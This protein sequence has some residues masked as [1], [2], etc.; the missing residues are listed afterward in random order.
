MRGRHRVS[1]ALL[2]AGLACGTAGVAMWQA[3][4]AGAVE[5]FSFELNAG[6]RGV[7]VFS[8]ALKDA[9]LDDPGAAIGETEASL[10][11]GPVGHGMA[12]VAWPGP[13]AANGGTLLLVLQ[14]GCGVTGPANIPNGATPLCPVPDEAAQQANVPLRAEAQSGSEVPTSTNDQVPG[15]HLTA[16]ALKDKVSGDATVNKI[17]GALGSLGKIVTHSDSSTSDAGGAAIGTSTVQDVSLGQGAVKIQSIIST[18]KATT[19]G[20]TAGGNG[21]T[22]ISGLTIGGQPATIDQHG[23]HFG[24]S[25]QP[26]NAVANQLAQQALGS[27]G[28]GMTL[29]APTKEVKGSAAVVGAPS[30]VI[31]IKMGD[32]TW[33]L[34]FGGAKASVT[35]APGDSSVVDDLLGGSFD[36]SSSFDSGGAA[37]TDVGSAPVVD[38]PSSSGTGAGNGEVALGPTENAVSKGRPIRP[39]AVL[40]GVLAAGLLA[41]GMKRLSDEAL[42]E[43][44]GTSC[45]LDGE[46]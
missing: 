12:A 3:S 5:L 44:A 34:I 39:G 13:T 16:T 15:V 2:A 42:V 8:P 28:I 14:P 40:L 7:N 19:D 32:A 38:V 29:G 4:P 20:T 41:V 9:T 26:A 37:F 18:A 22:V 43:R 24:G 35:G 10:E 6:A 31:S 21:T 1:A 45:P 23:L 46:G 25:N 30:L 33:Y 36:S 27:A 17:G 11:S